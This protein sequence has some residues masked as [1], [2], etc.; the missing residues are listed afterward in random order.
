[1]TCI[2]GP[3]NEK[4]RE[5]LSVTVS[6]FV[7]FFNLFVLERKESADPSGRAV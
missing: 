5:F 2:T 7:K 6:Y 4:P 1:M 3:Q